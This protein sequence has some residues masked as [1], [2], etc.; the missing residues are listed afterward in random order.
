MGKYNGK[1]AWDGKG[2]G[3][4][5]V[6]YTPVADSGSDEES[7]ENG[8]G[9]EEEGLTAAFKHALHRLKK[10]ARDILII[11]FVCFIVTGAIEGFMTGFKVD[12]VDITAGGGNFSAGNYSHG[13]YS[14]GNFSSG[15]ASGTSNGTA[16]NTPA[17]TGLYFPG[18]LT[19]VFGSVEFLMC[20][21]AYCNYQ[22]SKRDGIGK[23]ALREVQLENFR[24]NSSPVVVAHQAPAI[25]ISEFGVAGSTRDDNTK[26]ARADTFNAET[27]AET[28]RA[29]DSSRAANFK[30]PKNYG[31]AS[32]SKAPTRGSINSV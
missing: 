15:N 10:P 1:S 27:R 25:I 24:H 14:H 2:K 18:F 30:P 5:A 13:N 23:D 26:G 9:T 21:F 8:S 11:F 19:V 3:K 7:P 4:T 12:P 32:T 22:K 6:K 16:T 28:P 29:A 17:P 31:T 20:A